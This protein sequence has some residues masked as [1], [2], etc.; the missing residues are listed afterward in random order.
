MGENVEKFTGRVAAYAE[1][2][3]RYD[4][5]I[6]LPRLRDWCGLQQAWTVADVGAGTG[7]LSDVFLAGGNRV[8]A[9]EPNTEMR[10]A[11]VR[12]HEDNAALM[13][14]NGTAEATGL[15]DASVEMVSVGR[16]LHWFNLDQTMPEF[17]RILKPEGWVAV[18]AFGRSK[19]GRK[20]NEAYEEVLRPYTLNGR[21]THAEYTKYERLKD[22]FVGGEF[23]QEEV[24]GEIQIGWEALRG[25]TLSLS[26]A[27]LPESAEF[28]AFEEKLREYFAQ[29]EENGSVTLATRYW[30]NAGRFGTHG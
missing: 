20:E 15:E 3:E 17:R 14:V 2:R 16:A 12:L 28:G 23:R 11:C 30:I 5:M 24:R 22:L 8:I 18:V 19:D 26:H 6:V 21:G 10:E 7:M 4:P 25:F 29:Y 13:V 1:Y 9:V 27:P